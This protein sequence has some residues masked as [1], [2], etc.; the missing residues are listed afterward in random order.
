MVAADCQEKPFPFDYYVFT[1]RAPEP[2]EEERQ[3]GVYL[4]GAAE[5]RHLEQFFDPLYRKAGIGISTS[6]DARICGK[7]ALTAVAEAVD[8]ATRDAERRTAEWPVITG[9]TFEPF[10][11]VRGAPIVKQA[12]RSRLLDFLRQV[13]VI[14]EHA[15]A[16]GGHVHFG[17]GG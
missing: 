5:A 2:T 9:Y 7:V 4:V 14:V 15:I 13:R 11:E 1:S 17:G 6:D 3:S 8:A 16:V 10:Q 12:S